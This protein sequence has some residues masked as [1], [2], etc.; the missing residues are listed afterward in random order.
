MRKKTTFPPPAAREG[1]AQ[2]THGWGGGSVLTKRDLVTAL[3]AGC[4]LCVFPTVYCLHTGL[5]R[6][7]RGGGCLRRRRRCTMV[8]VFVFSACLGGVL[9][10]VAEGDG[11]SG[12]S[13]HGGRRRV[14]LICAP[15]L[16]SR[17]S[18]LQQG[19]CGYGRTCSR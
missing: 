19:N 1:A 4:A 10:A 6:G 11:P 7:G 14:P 18:L 9:C 2:Q 13:C 5:M 8:H 17:E 16:R 15:F 12:W 3:V